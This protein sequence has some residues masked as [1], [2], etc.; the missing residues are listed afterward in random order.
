[1]IVKDVENV[2]YN[3]LGEIELSNG[4]V[5][6]CKVLEIDGTNAVVQ[7]LSHQQELTLLTAR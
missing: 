1:M 5:R 2:K 3:E 7:L 4:E 6:K